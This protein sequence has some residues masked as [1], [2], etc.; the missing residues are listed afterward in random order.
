M[1]FFNGISVQ[2][3][4]TFA[5]HR[6]ELFRQ[7]EESEKFLDEAMY[8]WINRHYG[9]I[10]GQHIDLLQNFAKVGSEL[11]KGTTTERQLLCQ[12]YMCPDPQPCEQSFCPLCRLTEREELGF[13]DAVERA[14]AATVQSG[15]P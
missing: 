9:F 1:S 2:S 4:F 12:V 15:H 6:F 3:I 7:F 5:R 13:S 11:R 14:I 8:S 10:Q